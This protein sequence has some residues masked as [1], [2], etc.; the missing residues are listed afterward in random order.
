MKNICVFCGSSFGRKP[1]YARAARQFGAALASRDLGLVYGGGSIGLMGAVADATL[2]AGAP[3]IG[4]IP[5]ALARREIAH[6]GLTRLEVVPSMHARKARMARLSDAFVAM[7]G[8]IGTLEELFEV[9]T[10]G[11]LGIHVKPT[12]LLDVGGYWKPLVRLLDHAVEEGFL[13]PEHRRLVVI[14]RSPD[15]LLARL[16]AHRVPAA[17]RWI[18]EKE[19]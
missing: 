13:R 11:Y 10:W 14:D 2:E 1:A 19:T 17:T 18:G 3:V 7:P 6:H 15:R 12:G 8:G 16:V 4:I 5:R 9:L